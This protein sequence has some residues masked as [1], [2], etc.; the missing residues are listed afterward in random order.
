M[1]KIFIL[2]LVFAV[3]ACV[4]YV[5]KTVTLSSS[6]EDSFSGILNYD[7]PYSGT[8]TLNGPSNESFSGRFVVIDKTAQASS[9]GSMV[10]L[11]N[12]PLPS[13]AVF[14]STSTGS[15]QAQGFWSA[16]GSKGS[17]MNC[18]LEIGRAGHGNG[19]CKHSDGKKYQI[20]L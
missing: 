10:A 12:N 5:P 4:S 1:R 2:F 6:S 16:I 17:K 3:T 7:G 20:M 11:T 8:I 13:T 19:I 14:N 15:L 18:T 9:Q